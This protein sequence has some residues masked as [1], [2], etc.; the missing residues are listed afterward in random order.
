MAKRG[1][2]RDG[3]RTGVI[4]FGRFPRLELPPAQVGQLPI[5]N[6][7]NIVQQSGI[8]DNYTDIAA[9]LKLAL[10][11]FPEGSSKRIVL[12][13]DGNENLGNAVEQA[14]LAKHNGVQIDAV[15]IAAGRRNLNEVMVERI[16]APPLSDKASKIPS[17]RRPAQL[18]P[19]RRGRQPSPG[20]QYVWNRTRGDDGVEF[21]PEP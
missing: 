15:A 5:K 6:L 10:A 12:I 20:P 9:A 4:V 11:S 18:H 13:S 17:A 16:E 19:G 7:R 1:P 21:V 3:D 2:G 8:D 14:R